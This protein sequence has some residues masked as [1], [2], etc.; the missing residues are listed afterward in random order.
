MLTE[1]YT[2]ITSRILLS[3]LRARSPLKALFLTLYP[4]AVQMFFWRACNGI[5]PTKEKLF[6]Q[7]VVEDPICPTCGVEAETISHALWRCRAV[8]SVW[9]ECSGPIQKSVSADDD[10][11][12]IFEHLTQRLERDELELLATIAQKVWHRRNRVVFG[13][14]IMPPRRLSNHAKET[15]EDFRKA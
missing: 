10:F 6:K 13:G 9:T 4:W 14:V 8:S 5:L 12:T 1:L 11:L 3:L 2:L 15:L 7:K